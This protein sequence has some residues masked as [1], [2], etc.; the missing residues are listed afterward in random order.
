MEKMRCPFCPKEYQSYKQ[1]KKH[2]HKIHNGSMSKE[3][4]ESF[5]RKFE[6]GD[7][8]KKEKEV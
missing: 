1:L 6:L 8:I 4:V 7:F 3:D 5:N 2:M